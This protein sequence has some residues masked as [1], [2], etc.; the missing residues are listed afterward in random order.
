MGFNLAFKGLIAVPQY[1]RTVCTMDMSVIMYCYCNFV[2][3]RTALLTY[4]D[5]E[6]LRTLLLTL[7]TEEVK[8]SPSR[9][10][11]RTLVYPGWSSTGT[12]SG[13]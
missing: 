10:R 7:D 1:Y 6:F 9:S 4:L 13:M 8:A 12:W 11:C 5:P 2:P 3:S